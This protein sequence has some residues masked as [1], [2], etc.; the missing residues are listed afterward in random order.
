MAGSCT[1]LDLS[2][3]DATREAVAQDPSAGLG[4]FT[5]ETRWEDGARART[6]ARSF[7]I[8]T[9]EPAPL[10]GTDAAVDP[11]ELLLA[12]V[13]TCLTIGWV[14][15]AAKRGIDF[16]DLRIDVTGDFDLRGYLALDDEVRPGYTN[17]RY[18]VHVDS[19][20]TPEQLEEIRLAAERTSPMLDNVKAPTPVIGEVKAV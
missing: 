10:G 17:V 20:A 5:T 13:G 19:D 14:T 16:R 7:T 15:Q 11:M 18:T 12:A 6:V 9:D 1:T 4:T 3:F 8:E 2:A